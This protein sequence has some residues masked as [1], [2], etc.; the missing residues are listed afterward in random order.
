MDAHQNQCKADVG[1]LC[2]FKSRVWIQNFRLFKTVDGGVTWKASDFFKGKKVSAI[3]SVGQKILFA[4]PPEDAN[5]AV[6]RTEDGGAKWTQVTLPKTN[7]LLE[8]MSWISAAEGYAYYGGDAACG[9]QEKAIYYTGNKGKK[10]VIQSK[11]PDAGS[12]HTTSGT[13]PF[14]GQV[15]GIRF[16]SNRVGYVG[17]GQSGVLKS[18]DGGVHFSELFKKSDAQFGSGTG[19]PDFIN[20]NEGYALFAGSGR[21]NI[22]E[23]TTNGGRKWTPVLSVDAIAAFAK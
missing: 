8:D 23:H 2:K 6:Y 22:L 14:S 20:C 13:L 4:I 9:S 21:S 5:Q 1:H 12:G 3:R 15:S 17:G 7:K 16:F 18:T 11:S 19:V 10:W